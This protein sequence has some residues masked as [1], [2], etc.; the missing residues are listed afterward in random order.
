MPEIVQKRNGLR[1]LACS[2]EGTKLRGEPDALEVIAQALEHRV[3]LVVIPAERFDEGFFRLSTRIAGEIVQKFVNYRLRLVI[4]G[5]LSERLA[6]SS[7]LRGFVH[8]TNRGTQ[9]WFVADL[10]ELDT[11]LGPPGVPPSATD[12][13]A[14]PET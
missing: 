4:V 11:R 10:A 12:A 8:E 14:H 6:N 9:V 3:D 1:V 5:D 2:A 13:A 7:T